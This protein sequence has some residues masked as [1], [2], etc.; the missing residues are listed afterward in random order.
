MNQTE[1][2]IVCEEFTAS[3]PSILADDNKSIVF[4]AT[5][6]EADAPNRNKRIYGKD[7]LSE[8]LNNPTV[9][10]KI[11]HKAFYGKSPC[12]SLQ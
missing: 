8:A 6:Q 11:A 1:G 5:L 7:V 3:T 4:E 10:E 12:P 2:F 9:R